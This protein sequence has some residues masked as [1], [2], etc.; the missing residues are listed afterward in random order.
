MLDQLPN[1]R[2]IAALVVL[3]RIPDTP[4]WRLSTR[5]FKDYGRSK[6]LY[7]CLEV[8]WDTSEAPFLNTSAPSAAALSRKTRRE[9]KSG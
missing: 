4:Q 2:R 8:L 6:R 1:A 7:F 9:T 3:S 5:L